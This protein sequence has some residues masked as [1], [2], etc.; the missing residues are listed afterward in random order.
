M[1]LGADDVSSR[2]EETFDKRK[3]E[4]SEKT[5]IQTSVMRHFCDIRIGVVL[6]E[7]GHGR[8]DGGYRTH[9]LLEAWLA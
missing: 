8:L 4:E 1:S 9:L 6:K 7:G 2:N 5:V 3:T